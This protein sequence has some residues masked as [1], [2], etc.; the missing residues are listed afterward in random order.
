MAVTK[1]ALKLAN[2]KKLLVILNPS[3]VND[4][5][6]NLLSLCDYVILNETE[7]SEITGVINIEKA[8]K[9]LKSLNTIVTLGENGVYFPDENVKFDALCKDMVVDTTG[10]GDIFIGAFASMIA[11]DKRPI[12]ALDFAR[13][14]ASLSCTKEGVIESIPDINDV[15]KL[16]EREDL[17]S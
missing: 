15:L 12:E 16:I 5:A 17:I 3:P 6:I 13:G 4:E 10:A 1:Y 14:A 2:E 9:Y 8:T 7:L 11:K